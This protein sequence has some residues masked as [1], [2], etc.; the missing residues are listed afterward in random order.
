[1]IYDNL[2]IFFQ[3]VCKNMLTVNTIL[4]TYCHFDIILIQE[5]P[6]SITHSISSL[7]YSEGKVLV[8][9]PHHPNWLSFTKPSVTQLDFLRVLAYINIRL[10]SFHFSLHRDIINHRDIL[11]ISFFTNNICSF[12]INIY[13]DTSHSTLK[14]LKD[15]EVN[16]NNLLIMTS[17][18]NIRD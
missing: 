12:I 5:F 16:I 4:K 7:T 11:V 1:M 8:R 14:Y 15:T 10:S 18:F 3:N 17:D 2:K 13:S 9:A 6:W